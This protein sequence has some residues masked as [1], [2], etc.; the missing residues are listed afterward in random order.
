[1]TE[2]AVGASLCASGSHVWSGT[3]GSFTAKPMNR[4]T[5][6]QRSGKIV[7]SKESRS[8]EDGDVEGVRTDREGEDA[9]EHEGRAGDRV[10]TNLV[11]EYSLRPDPQMEISRNIGKS[12]SSQKRKK[13]RK[14]SAVNTPRTLRREDHQAGV[15]GTRATR[16]AEGDED[17]RERKERGEDDERHAQCRPRRGGI[18]D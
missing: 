15:V 11:A 17:R 7:F 13:S 14:S 5:N 3:I 9:G 18:R 4:S 1:M 2:T 6:I 8:A 12:S 16:D 10:E